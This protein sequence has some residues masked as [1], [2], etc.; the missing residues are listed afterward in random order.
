VI[1]SGAPAGEGAPGS[2]LLI[3]RE[4][5]EASGAGAPM[6]QLAPCC[7]PAP[8]DPLIG[9][10][11]PNKGIVAHV[12][13]CP[14]AL[15]RVEERRVYLAWEPDLELDC[16]AVVEVRTSNS[17]GLLAEMSRAFSHHGI[18]IKQA[19][20]RTFDNG[21]RAINTFHTTIRS[22]G[23]L[24]TLMRALGRIPGVLGVERVFSR[25]ASE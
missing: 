6:I 17:V 19:N 5:T 25:A 11:S 3:T 2:P 16:P 9:H 1:S 8:G 18:N 22:L 10:F 23:Q 15:E 7:S 12:E 24:T 20:C 4:R 13:T 14:E 21:Q